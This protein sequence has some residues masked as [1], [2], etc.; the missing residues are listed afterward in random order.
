MCI[1]ASGGGTRNAYL[2]ERLDN[3]MP[4]GLRL[5][6][7]RR[8][9][10]SRAVQGGDQVCHFGTWH[11]QSPRQQ[12][13]RGIGRQELRRARQAGAA[14]ARGERR[15]LTVPVVSAYLAAMGTGEKPGMTDSLLS[16]DPGSPTCRRRV[17]PLDGGLASG[18]LARPFWEERRRASDVIF[19]KNSC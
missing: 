12:Q 4:K 1:M 9:W 5:T 11:Y 3:Y 19:P 18:T 2:M 8:V 10:H 7:V 14:T 16:S 6:Q 17:L 15:K 13:S